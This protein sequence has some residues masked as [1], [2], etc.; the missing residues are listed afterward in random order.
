MSELSAAAFPWATRSGSVGEWAMDSASDDNSRRRRILPW[1]GSG[2]LVSVTSL[3]LVGG[4]L[5]GVLDEATVRGGGAPTR[6]G[7]F[8]SFGAALAMALVTLVVLLVMIG[9]RRVRARS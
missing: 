1:I 2:L 6:R 8:W 3:V 9:A 4:F 7:L 5:L